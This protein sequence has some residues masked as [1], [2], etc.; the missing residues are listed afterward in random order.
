MYCLYTCEWN[1]LFALKLY[2]HNS[3]TSEVLPPG[4]PQCLHLLGVWICRHT[5]SQQSGR[6]DQSL[7]SGLFGRV[8]IKWHDTNQNWIWFFRNEH[9]ENN[10]E[11]HLTLVVPP[12]AIIN[13]RKAGYGIFNMCF[14]MPFPVDQG[15]SKPLSFWLWSKAAALCLL[16]S[17]PLQPQA[18]RTRWSSQWSCV[19]SW[20][21]CLMLWCLFS[22]CSFGM[23][24]S[25]NAVL[26]WSQTSPVLLTWGLRPGA[27]LGETPALSDLPSLA[28]APMGPCPMISTLHLPGG[29]MGVPGCRVSKVDD[30][31]QSFF[32]FCF[33]R[34]K[35]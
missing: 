33:F 29:R 24:V 20:L 18:V 15:G 27:A 1:S 26:C 25:S 5:Q 11:W 3:V 23:R 9:Y 10:K 13:P 7:Q 31:F 19:S 32:L 14:L 8:A 34:Y 21:K 6:S 2:F 12:Y 4:S 16:S 17:P 28:G 22:S 35:Y 30:P